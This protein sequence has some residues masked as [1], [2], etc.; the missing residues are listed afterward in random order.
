MHAKVIREGIHWMGAVD[1]DR[2]WFDA[3]VPTPQGT[4][5]NAWLV[6]GTQKT[7]LLDTVDDSMACDLMAQLADVPRV[8]FVVAHHAEQD[9]SGAL[10]KVLERYPEAIVLCTSKAVGYLQDLLPLPADRLRA[11]ADNETLDLGGRTLQFLH[12]PWVH[13]PETMATYLVE[14]R[15]LFSCDLFGAHLASAGL[16]AS[17]EEVLEPAKRYYAEIM[18]PFRALVSKHI[19]RL[20]ALPIDLICPSHGPAY[21]DTLFIRTAWQQ[22]SAGA[23]VSKVVIPYVSMHG[24]T[25]RMVDHLV[26]A[27]SARGV[28]AE[29]LN[30]LVNDL[31]AVAMALVDPATVVFATP[32]VLNGLHPLV[33][34]AAFVAGV[35]KPKARF[36]ATISSYSWGGKID[37]QVR[38]LLGGLKA[39]FLPPVTCKGAPKDADFA[40]LD[41]LA[42]TIVA[43][44][45]EAGL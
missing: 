36:A 35:L 15:V 26:G 42:D 3:L 28:P 32:V 22:W 25:H 33:Q 5:Y 4:S 27:L 14:D 10:P 1:W 9:H 29:P 24:S 31:G 41:A 21:D 2:R 45:R 18:M 20:A 38:A 39:E 30:L 37:E 23:P 8:D 13:W 43:K 16:F 34:S 19:E 40:A 7:V 12:L 17:R 11:V 44:H 6:E